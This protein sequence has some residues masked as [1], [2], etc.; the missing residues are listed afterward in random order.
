MDLHKRLDL[1]AAAQTKVWISDDRQQHLMMKSFD[2]L[3]ERRVGE[4]GG[5]DRCRGIC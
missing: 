2:A 3:C 1:H 5:A 4:G